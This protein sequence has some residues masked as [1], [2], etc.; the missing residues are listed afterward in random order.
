ME[1]EAKGANWWPGSPPPP[2]CWAAARVEGAWRLLDPAWAGPPAPRL[3]E[4][5]FLTDPELLSFSHLPREPVWQ[6][7][8]PP[9]SRQEFLAAPHLTPAFLGLG[10]ELEAGPAGEARPWL[11]RDT[12]RL[13]LLSFTPLRYKVGAVSAMPACSAAVVPAERGGRGGQV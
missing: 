7:L 4:H 13:A 3:A 12:A 2:H 10:L 9:L 1:G 8:H 6:L 11:A 5:F